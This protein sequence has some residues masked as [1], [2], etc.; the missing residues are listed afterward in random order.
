MRIRCSV[1]KSPVSNLRCGRDRQKKGRK[2][3]SRENNNVATN[4]NLLLFTFRKTEKM[5]I[6]FFL[7]C[8]ADLREKKKERSL[9]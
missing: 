6:S 5:L 3:K 4:G 2:H 9:S 8:L 1:R 7:N